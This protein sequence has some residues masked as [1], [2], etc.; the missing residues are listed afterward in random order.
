MATIDLAPERPAATATA[1]ARPLVLHARVVDGTGGGPDKT[2]LNSPRHLR[3]LG[4]E[5]QCLYLRPPGDE[6]FR[7]LQ[8][9]A[10]RWEAPLVVLDDRGIWDLSVIRRTLEVCR[11]ERVA[12]WHGHDY[13]S[14]L[15]GLLV[16]RR[17]PMRL[18]TTAHGWVHHTR[19]TGLYY[20]LDR[21][22]MRRYERVICVSQDLADEC[23]RFGVP[24]DR[25]VQI[26]NA[27]DVE[28]FARRQSIAEAKRRL[29]WPA[30]RLLIGAVGR[31]AEEKGFD[32]LIR[33][34]ARLAADGRDVGVAIAGDGPELD[35]LSQLVSEL[36]VADRVRLL[37]FV[38]DPPAFYEAMDVYA[39]SSRREGLPN[40]LLEAM[41]LEVPIVAT[42]VAG[43]PK[44]VDDG[45]S[46]HLIPAEDLG[47]LVATLGQL[48]DDAALRRRLGQA[49]RETV[50]SRFSFTARMA[51]I[52]AV[53]DDVLAAKGS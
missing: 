41:A 38:A 48:C 26:D 37:G 47:A 11:R 33:A 20:A 29:G 3:S 42:R 15:L 10:Q 22:A 44:L 13:K 1:P 8:E 24:P 31:L 36:G 30:E 19:R 17:H 12:I 43:V 50:V 2:I 5:C 6:R 46:G 18:V 45:V 4:Y 14:N 39:L 35:R 51:K 27:I 16:Q 40:V 25:V 9:R 52:A 21:W 53:Y 23:R 7:V 34:V 32:V 28:E 49:G